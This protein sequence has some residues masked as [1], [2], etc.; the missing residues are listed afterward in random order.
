MKRYVGSSFAAILISLSGCAPAEQSTTSGDPAHSELRAAPRSVPTKLG[1][2]RCTYPVAFN[3]QSAVILECHLDSSPEDTVSD[4]SY[5]LWTGGTTL[6]DLSAVRQLP[7]LGPDEAI[8]IIGM[9]SDGAVIGSVGTVGDNGASFTPVRGFRA[10]IDGLDEYPDPITAVSSDGEYFITWREGANTLY[11]GASPVPLAPFPQDAQEPVIAGRVRND[12]TVGG[13]VTF[14][15]GG[16]TT[17]ASFGYLR[18]SASVRLIP[19]PKPLAESSV[20][21][22][23]LNNSGDIVVESDAGVFALPAPGEGNQAIEQHGSVAMITSDGTTREIAPA[24][25][26]NNTR[27]LGLNDAGIVFGYTSSGPTAEGVIPPNE[28]FLFSPRSGFMRLTDPRFGGEI[29]S[30][31]GLNNNNEALVGSNGTLAVVQLPSDL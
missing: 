2:R 28:E 6:E 3:D 9:A 29:E 24:G 31:F 19:S 11:H 30:I 14:P 5:A 16:N 8:N 12:G 26:A 23:L 21:S 25:G 13:T 1:N 15:G 17:N 4:I 7:S 27:A 10:R 20:V 22:M 18:S